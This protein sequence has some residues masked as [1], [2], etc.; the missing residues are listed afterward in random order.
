MSIAI[1]PTPVRAQPRMPVADRLTA[2]LIEV[3]PD[4]WPGD[5]MLLS[6]LRWSHYRRVVEARDRV[7]RG[8]RV[9]FDQGRLEVMTVSSIH[10]QWKKLLA[11][12]GECLE[13]ELGYG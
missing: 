11:M 1:E 4:L 2:A 6:G 9:T 12:L 10:E 13:E 3:L 8:A 7:R 5:P